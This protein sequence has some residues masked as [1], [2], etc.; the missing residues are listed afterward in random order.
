MTYVIS[1]WRSHPPWEF[2]EKRINLVYSF[3]EE[4]FFCDMLSSFLLLCEFG[5]LPGSFHEPNKRYD[6]RKDIRHW[7][8]PPEPTDTEA[9]MPR[10]EVGKR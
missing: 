2:P 8:C 10:K 1:L 3:F 4:D 6:R 5:V 7:K 9:R